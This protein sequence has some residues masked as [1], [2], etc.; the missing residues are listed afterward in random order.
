MDFLGSGGC[1]KIPPLLWDPGPFGR[2]R[3]FPGSRRRG[4]FKETHMTSKGARA[5]GLALIGVLATSATWAAPPWEALLPFKKVEANPNNSYR[6]TRDQG[7][8]LI[9]TATF[10]G[11]NADRQA[12]ELVLELR[13]RFKLTAYLHEQ[14]YDFTQPVEG[15]G[16]DELGRP[17]QMRYNTASRYNTIAVLVGDFASVEDPALEKT[18]DAVKHARPSCLDLQNRPTSSQRYAIL[19][20]AYRR[21]TDDPEKKKR[22]PMGSAFVTRNPLLPEEY[23]VAGGLDQFVVDM[24]KDLELS[25]LKCK[26]P[27]TVRVATFRGKGTMNLQQMAAMDV[28][29]DLDKAAEKAH[30]LAVALR[31]QGVEAYE[32]H[33]RHESIVTI[34]SFDAVG[35]PLPDGRTEL[36]PG[37]LQI[38]QT[39]GAERTPLPGMAGQLGL[40][41]KTLNGIAFDAQPLPVEVPRI[42]LGAAYSNGIRQVRY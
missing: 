34:G 14:T 9:L 32:F 23:F 19:K 25:L 17:K 12:H 20:E 11:E 3:R 8:W 35:Q 15:M 36:H 5:F 24:N 29:S 42:S 22:G 38:M 30:K 13:S 21:I 16:F 6:L 7:P 10:S 41:P 18:L 31:K 40:R 28:S 39:Y 4:I 2:K 33:D 1:G 26:R 37:I 27:Y